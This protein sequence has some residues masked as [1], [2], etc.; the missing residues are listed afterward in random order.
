MTSLDHQLASANQRK[1]QQIA[2]SFETARLVIRSSTAADLDVTYAVAQGSAK[3]LSDWMPWAHP[4]PARES[5]AQYF[6]TCEEKWRNREMLDFQWIEKAT[7]E[8][9]GK[10]AFH[11]IDWM[12]PKFEIGYWLNTGYTGR[13]FC[14]EAVMGLVDFAR[15]ELGAVRLEIR[16]QPANERSRAVAERCGFVLE[17]VARSAILGA[18][19]SLRDACM[20]AK[21]FE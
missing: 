7:G 12:L 5:M 6:S 3:E 4:T 16:S 11:H 14:S 19:N 8:L 1:S 15:T 10:G 17:G 21:V 18:D 13:G 2:P 20:Y 9:V